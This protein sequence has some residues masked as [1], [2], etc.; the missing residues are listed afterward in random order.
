[1]VAMTPMPIIALMTSAALT[2]ILP[3]SSATVIVSGTS[4]SRTTGAVGRSKPCLASKFA[5]SARRG[6]PARRPDLPL[7][8]CSWLRP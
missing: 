2:A 4:T 3:A 6:L 1:M 7:A 8:T 5:G